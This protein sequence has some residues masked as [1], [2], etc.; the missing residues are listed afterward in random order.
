MKLASVWLHRCLTEHITCM[1]SDE[2]FPTLPSRVLDV[3]APH[4][5]S[6]LSLVESNGRH[7]FYVTLS[8]V[9]GQQNITRTTTAKLS[10]RKQSI[11]LDSLSQTFQ[12]AITIIRKL[13]IRYIWIDSLCIVQD[14][15]EDWSIEA[16][17]MGSYYSNSLFNIAAVSS[18]DSKVGCF[19]P[20]EPDQITPCA[21]AI[22]FP[23]SAGFPENTSG[24]LFGF[25]RPNL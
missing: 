13:D 2:P 24:H 14:D 20:Y 23:A 16:S 12:N 17:K 3:D 15:P 10:E 5:P 11:L 1:I 7:G 25:I 18:H 6:K 4:S 19:M 9:W 21:V 8:H 22:E